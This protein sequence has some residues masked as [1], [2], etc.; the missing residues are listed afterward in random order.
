MELS[1]S[2]RIT[3]SSWLTVGITNRSSLLHTKPSGA[4]QT[5]QPIVSSSPTP[6]RTHE[7]IPFASLAQM[8]PLIQFFFQGSPYFNINW[9]KALKLEHW[10]Q[11][12]KNSSFPFA[13]YQDT[14]FLMPYRC[15]W[16]WVCTEKLTM[17][18]CLTQWCLL[19]LGLP[20]N[21]HSLPS[22]LANSSYLFNL[23]SL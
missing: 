16:L 3:Y 15:P 14:S 20:A 10:T 8:L 11:W 1:S 19:I 22:S 4:S 9:A 21:E 17:S 2:L 7:I 18:L 13:S 12:I 5:F 6:N 23:C